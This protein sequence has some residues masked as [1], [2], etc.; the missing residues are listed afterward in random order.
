[1][2]EV[3]EKERVCSLV[4]LCAVASASPAWAY[5][6]SRAISTTVSTLAAGLQTRAARQ[7]PLGLGTVQVYHETPKPI[8]GYAA[9]T[10]DPGPDRGQHM[11]EGNKADVQFLRCK[12]RVNYDS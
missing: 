9:D 6:R 5:N 11:E 12:G 2:H 8:Q 7:G 1:M 10:R 3:L 4:P